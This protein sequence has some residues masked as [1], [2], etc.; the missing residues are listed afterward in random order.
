MIETNNYDAALPPH[1][2]DNTTHEAYHS[3]KT[4]EVVSPG[5]TKNS[6]NEWLKF[7]QNCSFRQIMFTLD[8]NNV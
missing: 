4:G 2:H 3:D 5:K 1:I 6:K 8:C 7:T